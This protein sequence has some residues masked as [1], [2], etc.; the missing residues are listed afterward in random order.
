MLKPVTAILFATDLSENCRAAL[1]FTNAMATRFQ[2]KVFLLHV[3]EDLPEG[4][5]GMLKSLLG[6]HKWQDIVTAQTENVHKSLTGKTTINS[7]I[8]YDIQNFCK[9]IGIDDAA[10]DTASREIL[11]NQGDVADTI[12]SMAK[13]TSCDLIVLGAK[14]G[15][16]S[17]TS[18]G[19][20]IKSVLK[21]SKIPVTIVPKTDG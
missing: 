1:D 10:C 18:V 20:I 9:V 21:G 4:V 7:K 12:I 14:K 3:V 16:F 17:K 13:E 2:A 8:R 15:V 19:G 11:I 5:D 6:R